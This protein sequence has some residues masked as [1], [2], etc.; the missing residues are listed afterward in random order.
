MMQTTLNLWVRLFRKHS[1]DR[2]FQPQDYSISGLSQDSSGF[3]I[4]RAS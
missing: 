2:G 3:A 1:I 4:N